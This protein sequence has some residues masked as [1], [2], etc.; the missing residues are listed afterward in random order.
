M[1]QQAGNFQKEERARAT[2]ASPDA[3]WSRHASAQS[4]RPSAQRP[5]PT[6][7]SSRQPCWRGARLCLRGVHAAAW[8]GLGTSASRNPA[9]HT[10][11]VPVPVQPVTITHCRGAAKPCYWL[12]FQA[13]RRGTGLPRGELRDSLPRCETNHKAVPPHSQVSRD[14]HDSD[15]QCTWGPVCKLRT[16]GACDLVQSRQEP[17]RCAE[18]AD[19]GPPQAQQLPLPWARPSE[20]A[21]AEF[22]GPA[23][24]LLRTPTAPSPTC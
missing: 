13:W 20:A 15:Y 11:A 8:T 21:D 17:D 23:L 3:E 2:G 5:R 7:S 22:L 18:R 1:C 10:A 16:T 6:N 12:V 14:P 19:M 24:T 4:P 9:L